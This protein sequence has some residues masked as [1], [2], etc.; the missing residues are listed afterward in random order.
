MGK[1]Y[2]PLDRLKVSGAVKK[3]KDVSMLVAKNEEVW[4]ITSYDLKCSA[5]H[6]FM[7]ACTRSYFTLYIV[8]K[9]W[10]TICEYAKS[11]VEELLLDKISLSIFLRDYTKNNLTN[12][13]RRVFKLF[14]Y[15]IREPLILTVYI[16]ALFEHWLIEFNFIFLIVVIASDLDVSSMPN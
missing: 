8:S 1:I 12:A 13:F 5:Q 11:T 10:F 4:F 15:K 2:D 14:I 3:S 16:K 6:N 7:I 9:T